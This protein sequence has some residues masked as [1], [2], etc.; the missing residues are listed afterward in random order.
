MQL[1]INGS[2]LIASPTLATCN[3]I[4]KPLPLGLFILDNFSL[5]LTKSSFF[6]TFLIYKYIGEKG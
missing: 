3:Q 2:T 6:L 5:N 4:K 1:S